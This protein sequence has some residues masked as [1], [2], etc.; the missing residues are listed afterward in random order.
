MIAIVNVDPNPRTIG[1][2]D[3]EVRINRQVICR[4]KHIRE[5]GLATCLEKAAEAV[6]DDQISALATALRQHL[7]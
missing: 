7:G 1:E 5:Q 3:Y 2:H 4:F 6:R